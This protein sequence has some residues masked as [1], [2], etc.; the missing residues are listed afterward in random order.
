M[1]LKF[2]KTV[3]TGWRGSY[4][5]AGTVVDIADRHAAEIYLAHGDALAVDPQ[6]ARGGMELCARCLRMKKPFK[7]TQDH[8]DW[9]KH[10]ET[11]ESWREW[12]NTRQ[13]Q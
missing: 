5:A 6:G 7:P 12:R 1:K 3:P 13:T 8:P 9:I 4:Y 11:D 2:L 10:K